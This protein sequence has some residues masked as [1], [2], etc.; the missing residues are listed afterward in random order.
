M[1]DTPLHHFVKVYKVFDPKFCAD[2]IRSV[3]EAD[4]TTHSY[5]NDEFSRMHPC[6][7]LSLG[8]EKTLKSTDIQS[9]PL[10]KVLD[11]EIP[12]ILDQYIGHDMQDM[13]WFKTCSGITPFR[14]NKYEQS[15]SMSTHWD[16]MTGITKGAGT[17][18][19]SML[20]SLNEGYEGGELRICNKHI[21]LDVG[22]VV[23]FPS[24]FL[25]PH[26]V[27]QV[28][29]GTRYSIAAWAW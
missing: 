19:L 11:Y 9:I 22:H 24:N 23:V 28:T 18:I 14:L 8:Q 29:F 12:K 2:L 27:K 21:K 17:P 13:T 6:H 10:K 25:Y 26:E 1:I 16:Y 15:A 5:Y 20:G 4:W 7:M 3:E